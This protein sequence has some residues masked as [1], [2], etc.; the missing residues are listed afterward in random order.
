MPSELFARYKDLQAYVGWS[1][2]DA[3]RVKSVAPLIESQAHLLID[4]FYWEIE[5]HPATLSVITGGHAQITRLKGS[6]RTW[7]TETLNGPVDFVYVDR[8]WKI[9]LQHVEV[10][11]HP[12]YTRAAMARFRNGLIKILA[13]NCSGSAT[14][15]CQI[16]QSFNKLLDLDIAIIQDAYHAEYLT[17]ERVAEHERSE[18][19]FRMLVEAAACMVVILRAENTIAY[20][21]PYSEELTGYLES[22]VMGRQFV[23]LF[24]PEK[25]RTEVS[26][27]IAT[28]FA[29]QPTKAYESPIRRRD[30]SQRW[31]VWNAQ[32]LDDF[33]GSPAVLAVGQDV[34]ERREAQER[35]LRSE[36][37]AGIGQMVTGIAHESRNALQRI[38]SCSE[39]L[40]L[41]IAG[42]V[43]AQRLVRRVQ[44]A[45]D[46]LL[47]LFDEVRGFVAPI[48]LEQSPCRIEHVWREAWQLLDTLRRGRDVALLE[49]INGCSCEF[50]L[51][52]FRMVQVFRNLL[53]NSL[54]ACRDPVAVQ[55]S[56]RDVQLQ[57]QPAIEISVRDNGPG[58]TPDARQNVFEPFFTT[59]TKGTG[60]GMAIARRIVEAHGGQIVVGNDSSVGA[61]FIIILPRSI[62]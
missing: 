9:G 53:E 1:D 51:D 32:R 12:A 43:E 41:E 27:E 42:N 46:H 19:N 49:K 30:G 36:R 50:S 40:E 28:T 2:D 10:G 13:E 14:E 21:S 58:L 60:L 17:R 56:C 7:L 52:R 23:P 11:L 39:M 22:E 6:L 34:T 24:V 4:D 33:E 45:Q 29:G 35:L 48:R 18:V 3:A 15:V 31:M 16:V 62:P 37:L 38:Q 47:H 25:E 59:K 57:E 26:H 20:F 55:V 61:E 54:A 5:R 44:E 8:R